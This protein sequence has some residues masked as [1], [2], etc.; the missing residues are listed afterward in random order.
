M[1][2]SLPGSRIRRLGNHTLPSLSL[3]SGALGR[4]G[5]TKLRSACLPVENQVRSPASGPKKVSESPSRRNKV[6]SPCAPSV[7][8]NCFFY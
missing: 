7:P 3:A 4:P 2:F 6:K 1:S 8:L 5:E